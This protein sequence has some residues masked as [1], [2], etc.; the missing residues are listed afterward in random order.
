MTLYGPPYHLKEVKVEVTQFCPLN[1]IHCSSI[2]NPNKTQQLEE[3]RVAEI[4]SDSAELR[5]QEIMFSGGEPLSWGSICDVVYQCKKL[6]MK[7]TIYT[8]GISAVDS[9]DD[10]EVLAKKLKRVGLST[11]ILS[12]HAASSQKHEYITRVAGSFDSTVRAIKTFRNLS[13]R[14]EI[15]FVPL[16]VNF[17]ELRGIVDL[18]VGAGIRKL[19]LLRFVPHGR[20]DLLDGV[21]QLSEDENRQLRKE[22]INLRTKKVIDIRLGS[23]YNIL[24][25]E[26]EVYCKAGIDRLVI[27]PQGKV[28]PCDAFKN[29][30]RKDDYGSVLDHS[31]HE[32]WEKSEYLNTVREC[33]ASGLPGVCTSCTKKSTCK[34]GCLAQKV[35]KH[36]NFR[37]H[38]DPDCLFH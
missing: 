37:K 16:G 12:L 19:S 2:S 17:K 22:I 13:I 1:C 3:E 7:P 27:N 29:I 25:L 34:S 15:H 36:R 8:T 28:F 23:P 26:S 14:C 30:D 4:I 5:V 6:G 33:L 20:G 32:I 31:L 38:K 10:V 21:A 18:A 35:I 24:C 11:A 9:N